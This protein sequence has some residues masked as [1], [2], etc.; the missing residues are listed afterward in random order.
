MRKLTIGEKMFLACYNILLM[1]SHKAGP[2]T[3]QRFIESTEESKDREEY[4]QAYN[5]MRYDYQDTP[6]FPSFRIWGY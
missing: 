3:E 4:R 2:I 6:S 1:Q 5:L